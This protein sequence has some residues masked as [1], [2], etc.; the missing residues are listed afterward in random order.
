MADISDSIYFPAT[1]TERPWFYATVA[2][3]LAAEAK[4]RPQDLWIVL[5]QAAKENWSFGN[6]EAQYA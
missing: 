4:V 2:E 5:I 3:R 6:G 1:R